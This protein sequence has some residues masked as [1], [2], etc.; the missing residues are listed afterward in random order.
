M[1][2]VQLELSKSLL[3]WHVNLTFTSTGAYVDE[4]SEWLTRHDNQFQWASASDMIKMTM[5]KLDE[6]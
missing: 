1:G 3:I 6:N 2:P 4:V 5:S